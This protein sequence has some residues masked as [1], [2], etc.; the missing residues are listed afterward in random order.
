MMS[1][2]SKTLPGYKSDESV[3]SSSTDDSEALADIVGTATS[4]AEDSATDVPTSDAFPKQ[5][6]SDGTVEGMNVPHCHFYKRWQVF[7]IALLANYRL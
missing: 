1:S 6:T 3:A 2:G 4:G 5:G 7:R